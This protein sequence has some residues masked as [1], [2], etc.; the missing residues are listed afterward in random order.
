MSHGHEAAY[1]WLCW[2]ENRR[3]RALFPIRTGVYPAARNGGGPSVAEQEAGAALSS[4]RELSPVPDIIRGVPLD[5]PV[6][7][8]IS[9]TV[10]NH[11]LKTRLVGFG[12]TIRH[13]EIGKAQRRE[14][15]EER[16][17]K[18]H[19]VPV[20]SRTDFCC[21]SARL[22]VRVYQKAIT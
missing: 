17:A 2:A 8:H 18:T 15:I 19:A 7:L 11:K 1:I 5:S 20:A 13:A 10:A 21:H 9:E 4:G 14:M 3:R 12:H 16:D 22:W 6:I